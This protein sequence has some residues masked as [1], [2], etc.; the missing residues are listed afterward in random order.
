MNVPQLSRE[1]AAL[2]RAAL[3][4]PTN[5]AKVLH[6]L[7]LME[8]FYPDGSDAEIDVETEK[9]REA[10]AAYDAENVT[11][12]RADLKEVLGL[13]RT[14]YSFPEDTGGGRLLAALGEA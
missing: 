5:E 3:L 1:Q 10:L 7:G 8:T 14:M 6:R 11:V 12:S 4:S 9:G 13:L 2:L